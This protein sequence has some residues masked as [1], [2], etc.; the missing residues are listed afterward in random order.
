[1]SAPAPSACPAKPVLPARP[2]KVSVNGVTIPRDAIARET[3]NHPAAT[4][5][6]AW[7]AAAR[8]LAIRELLLQE[9]RRINLAAAPLSDEEGRLETVEEALIRQ[10][11]EIEVATPKADEAACRRYYD[12]N[13][14]RFRTAPLHEASHILLPA[15]DAGARRQARDRAA[16]LIAELQAQPERFAELA[17]IHSACPS[18][19]QGGNLGQIG[20]GQ[21]VEEFEKALATAPVGRVAPEAVESRFGL[22]VVELAR[23]IEGRDLPFEMVRDRIAG[24]LEEKVRRTALH[25]YIS[26]LAARASV[27]G[28]DLLPGDL[29]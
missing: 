9:A 10:V 28:I 25:Q 19:A 18:A 4:P 21:T 26:M 8:A 1:M 5:I 22:H 29:T 11:V 24:W 13:R 2:R 14:A 12:N 6:D 3:Q 23:R 16:G 7:R 15:A 20:P 27:E 17:R